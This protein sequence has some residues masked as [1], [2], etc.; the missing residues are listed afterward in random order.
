MQKLK[1]AAIASKDDAKQ[2]RAR[3]EELGKQLAAAEDAQ[4]RDQIGGLFVAPKKCDY[5]NRDSFICLAQHILAG[6]RDALAVS[7]EKNA[8][9][10]SISFAHYP[11]SRV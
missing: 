11:I 4:A 5:A 1:T 3:V 8:N 6:A 7:E 10:V 9:I 2:Q